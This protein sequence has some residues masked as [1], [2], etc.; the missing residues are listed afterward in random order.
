MK[1]LHIKLAIRGGTE[2]DIKSVCT[3]LYSAI[4]RNEFVLC[5]LNKEDLHINCVGIP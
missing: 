5:N 4:V 3:E 2:F 1:T